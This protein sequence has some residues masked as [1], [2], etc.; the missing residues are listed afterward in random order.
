MSAEFYSNKTSFMDEKEN[1]DTIRI[2][3]LI[4]HFERSSLFISR[5]LMKAIVSKH[6]FFGEKKQI[7]LIIRSLD[8]SF[9]QERVT[10]ADS[11]SAYNLMDKRLNVDWIE[12]RAL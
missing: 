8:N 2:S 5:V 6:T 1:L 12:I 3:F 11:H 7:W 9:G 10:M 4:D